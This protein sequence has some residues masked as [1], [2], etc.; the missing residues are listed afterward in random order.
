[1]AQQQNTTN[2]IQDKIICDCAGTTE[3]KIQ[4]LIDDG[5][6]SLDRIARITGA[7]TGCGSCDILILEMLED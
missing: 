5:A 6:D 1:M 7:C 3:A 4:Q 2:T